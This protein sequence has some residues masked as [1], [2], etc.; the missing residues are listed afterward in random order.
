MICCPNCGGDGPLYSAMPIAPDG[1]E[2]DD[3]LAYDSVTH[4]GCYYEAEPE[5][6][7]HHVSEEVGP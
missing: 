1:E 2:L 3:L 7:R 6:V 5:A 4:C